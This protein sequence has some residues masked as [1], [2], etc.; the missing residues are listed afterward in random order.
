MK[1][2]RK[3]IKDIL[4]LSNILK[5]GESQTIK[6]PELGEI[7]IDKGEAGRKGYG[8]VHIIE[9]R[10]IEG[11]KEEYSA[12]ILY[13]VM[14]A[15]KGGKLIRK[16]PFKNNLEHK[17]RIELEKEGI[18]AILSCQRNQGDTEKWLLTGF[19]NRNKKEEAAEAIQTVIAQYS[20]S[21]EFSDFRKQVGA[22]VSSLLK[23]SLENPEKSSKNDNDIAK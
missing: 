15:A 6:N 16:I 23:S 13:L 10:A 4:L 21:L 11:K 2:K 19:D 9:K 17:G 1:E 20:H 14:K 3:A 5:S 12:A 8:L 18:I 7:T 22:T